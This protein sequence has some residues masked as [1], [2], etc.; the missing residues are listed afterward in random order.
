MFPD[1]I[2][3]ID[4]DPADFLS[5]D[6]WPQGSDAELINDRTGKHKSIR[7]EGVSGTHVLYS[8]QYKD[9]KGATHRRYHQIASPEYVILK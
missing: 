9:K 5:A 7:I 8:D 3:F 1:K 2:K 6:D 4:P